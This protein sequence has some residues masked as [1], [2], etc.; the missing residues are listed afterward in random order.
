[1][2]VGGIWWINQVVKTQ[3][4]FEA[5]ASVP[6]E[7]EE[8]QVGVVDPPPGLVGPKVDR[9]SRF[10]KV[11]L[12]PPGPPWPRRTARLGARRRRMAPARGPHACANAHARAA[13]T[14]IVFL[15][16]LFHDPPKKTFFRNTK[17]ENATTLTSPKFFTWVPHESSSEHYTNSGVQHCDAPRAACGPS[18]HSLVSPRQHTLYWFAH[19]AG[20]HARAPH[21]PHMREGAG[22]T[23]TH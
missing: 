18:L 3:N 7:S 2:D 20:G 6:G 17:I 16:I 10:R 1:M 11:S 22:T 5:L 9:P 13:L 21:C 8:N 15:G 4:R 14:Q 12:L 19:C 23:L